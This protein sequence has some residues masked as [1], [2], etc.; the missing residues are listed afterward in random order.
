[1]HKKYIFFF[2]LISFQVC[3]SQEYDISYEAQEIVK[4]RSIYLNGGIR[5][6]FGGK[7]RTY[8]K[9]DLPPNTV[10]W[11]YSF[12]TKKGR[13]G[14]KNL[15]LALQLS[16]MIIDPSTLTSQLASQLQIPS[17]SSSVDI[18]LLDRDNKDIFIKKGD[19]EGQELYYYEEGTVKNTKSAIVE[20]DDINSGT[21]YL[22]LKNPSSSSGVNISIEVAAVVANKTIIPKSKNQE[23][24]ELYGNL[25][26]TQFEKGN[27]EKCIEYSNKANQEYELGWV[28]ANKG[29]AQ[30]MLDNE[31]DAMESYINAIPLIRKQPQS[32]YFFSEVIKDIDNALK[33]NPNLSGA[34][35]IKQL[36]LMQ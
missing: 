10:K 22:G 23:K 33:V 29:L 9:I 3:F 24:A 14:V 27:Y 25:G 11:Y 19:N 18:Y 8:I 34:N 28:Y 12:S 36:L 4:T 2:L 6:Q 1:M 26:W 32:E 20:I 35:E 16:A 13:S 17:G 31:S 5:S 30:L 21:L 7:S 15:N